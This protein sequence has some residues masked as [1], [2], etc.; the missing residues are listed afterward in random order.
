MSIR[1]SLL[2]YVNIV[3]ASLDPARSPSKRVTNTR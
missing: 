1:S 3:E 2:E